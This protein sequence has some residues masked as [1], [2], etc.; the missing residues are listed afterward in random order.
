[1]RRSLPAPHNPNPRAWSDRGLYAA[2]LGHSTVLL[3]IDGVTILT[4]PVLG[5]RVGLKIGHTTV[6]PQRLVRPA[7]TV[8]RLPKIDLVLLS[9]AH[10]DHFDI[11]TLRALE[12]RATAVV[13][14]SRTG[15]LLRTSRYRSV[16][17]LGW[18]DRIWVGPLEIR[19]FPV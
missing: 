17:E 9:H 10:F 6:D 15:D 11:R 13:T 2:W 1:M 5:S 14:A 7:L 12:N 8:D 18:G 19:A 16:H 3:K 4:D